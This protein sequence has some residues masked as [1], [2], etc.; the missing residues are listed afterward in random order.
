MKWQIGPQLPLEGPWFRSWVFVSV[1]RCD[2]IILLSIRFCFCSFFFFF[3][4]AGEYSFGHVLTDYEV[5]LRC[6]DLNIFFWEAWATLMMSMKITM[7][8]VNTVSIQILLS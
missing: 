5:P 1:D 4:S 3:H 8:D 6:W 2:Q 7:T